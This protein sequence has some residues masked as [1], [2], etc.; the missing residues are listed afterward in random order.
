MKNSLSLAPSDF[1]AIKYF[2]SKNWTCTKK[3][4]LFFHKGEV[5]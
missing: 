4:H 5:A 3:N 2:C 1:A